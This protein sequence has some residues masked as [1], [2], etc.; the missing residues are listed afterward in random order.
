MSSV[1]SSSLGQFI[2]LTNGMIVYAFHF[3]VLC[4]EFRSF[5][6]QVYVLSL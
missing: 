6:E 5:V 1:I 3:D 4:L 2:M